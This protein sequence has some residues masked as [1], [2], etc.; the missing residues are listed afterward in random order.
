[1]IEAAATGWGRMIGR[2]GR[3]VIDRGDVRFLSEQALPDAPTIWVCWHEFN[4]VAIAVYARI[5]KRPGFAFVPRGAVGATVTGWL[6]G[7]G[8]A[9]IAVDGDARDGLALRRMREAIAGGGDIV[10][11]VDGPSGPRRKLRPGALWLAKAARAPVVAFGA[12]ATPAIRVPRW[13]RHLVPL[14]G[15][16]IAVA[17]N[18]PMTIGRGDLEEEAQRLT[19]ALDSE[20]NRAAAEIAS[21]A[22]DIQR[23]KVSPRRARR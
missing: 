7:S 3:S 12:A 1:M 16:R 17:M 20:A 23:D 9:P 22:G 4:L 15:A 21:P 19:A 14:P 5:R 2:Y 6:E 8:I 11:A 13:D 10:I 18:T